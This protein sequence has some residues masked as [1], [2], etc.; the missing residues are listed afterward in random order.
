MT[1]RD[2]QI[3]SLEGIDPE[4][5][6]KTAIE[7]F[8]KFSELGLSIRETERVIEYSGCILKKVKERSQMTPLNM[9]PIQEYGPNGTGH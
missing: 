8:R 2:K 1:G 4:K 9:I 6:E 3:L 5:I 7:T